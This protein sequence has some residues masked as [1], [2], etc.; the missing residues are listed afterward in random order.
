VVVV[1]VVVAAAAVVGSQNQ[2]YQLIYLVVF[3]VSIFIPF[4]IILSHFWQFSSYFFAFSA[5]SQLQ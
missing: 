1:V 4:F 5:I 3:L 2:F